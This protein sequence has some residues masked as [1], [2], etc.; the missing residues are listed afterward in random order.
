MSEWSRR[1]SRHSFDRM[2]GEPHSLPECHDAEKIPSPGKNSNHGRPASAQITT[3]AK[4]PCLTAPYV[5]SYKFNGIMSRGS[6]NL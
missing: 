2:P 3:Q 6:T 1:L 5:F 4:L